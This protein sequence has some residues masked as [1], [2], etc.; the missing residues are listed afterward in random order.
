MSV[1]DTLA[2]LDWKR[3]IFSLYDAVRALEPETG[4]M[5]WRETRD[6]LFRSHPQSPR[7]GYADLTY[8]DY[9]PAARVLVELE[10][11]DTAPRAI[12][13]SGPEPMLFRPFARA[14]F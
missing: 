3:R 14:H 9:D 6:E 4:W 13:T 5:L 1:A 8:Y 12:E 11:L 2:L 7:P 10:D